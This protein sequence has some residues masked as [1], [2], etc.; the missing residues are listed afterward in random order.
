MCTVYFKFSNI[1]RLR[2]V[3]ENILISCSLI[4]HVLLILLQI[5]VTELD[6]PIPIQSNKTFVNS[7]LQEAIREQSSGQIFR[8]QRISDRVHSSVTRSRIYEIAWQACNSR[9]IFIECS[10]RAAAFLGHLAHRA[11]ARYYP[12][13]NMS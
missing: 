7:V 2:L 3:N 5:V 1:L 10:I 4:L 12:F 6:L 11:S 13:N 8:G 9:G